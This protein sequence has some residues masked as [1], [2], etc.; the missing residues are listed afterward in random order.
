[1]PISR[2][3]MRWATV[4]LLIACGGLLIQP[5]RIRLQR[6]WIAAV[7]GPQFTVG[8][9]VYHGQSSIVE[10]RDLSWQGT[11]TANPRTK[12][13]AGVSAS[14]FV[15]SAPRCWLG[16]DRERLADGR[17]YLPKVILQ[18]AIITAANTF[19][20][21]NDKLEDWRHA[22]ARHQ[23]QF[24]WR[25]LEQRANCLTAADHSL[26]A[27]LL[28]TEDLVNRSRSILAIAARIE[29]ETETMDNPLRSEGSLRARLARYTE[30]IAAQGTLRKQSEDIDSDLARET[31]R[32]AEV[33]GQ[34]TREWRRTCA[35]IQARAGHENSDLGLDQ[36]LALVLAQA[37]WDQLAAFGEIVA[38]TSHAAANYRAADYD[39][40]V[41]AGTLANDHMHCSELKASGE[42][43]C[44][45]FS[46]PFHTNGSWRVAQQRPGEVFR[47]LKFVTLFDRRNYQLEVT[48]SHDSRVSSGID[49]RIRMLNRRVAARAKADAAGDGITI[50]AL[51]P[52]TASLTSAAG[53][54]SGTLCIAAEALPILANEPARDYLADL[55]IFLDNTPAE[56]QRQPLQF[57]VSGTWQIPEFKLSQ[58]AAP[59][60]QDAA[61]GIISQQSQ[62]VVAQAQSKL[63]AEFTLRIDQMRQRISV[64]VHAA[65]AAMSQDESR[66]LTSQQGLQQRLDEINGAEFARRAGPVQ[67]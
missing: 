15:V 6:V 54:L 57:E 5:A 23:Q 3:R 34:D 56:Q 31:E 26:A 59:W 64:A 62:E 55:Q 24:E 65:Q 16:V 30:L 51:T 42:F 45:Q 21:T 40:T 11:A 43:R 53:Q 50:N 35:Q 38:N 19:P 33:H 41:R 12:N 61:E 49:M 39:V 14:K 4:A 67:R 9:I 20:G 28:R 47:E 37:G 17:I 7:L 22:V 36:R 18:D 8:E 63:D 46:S 10:V 60:L 29:E 13:S 44:A 48:G 1:M 27:W 32:L 2:C 66:L 25:S 52:V 58:P